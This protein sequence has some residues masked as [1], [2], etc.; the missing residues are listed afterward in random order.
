MRG[1]KWLTGL[2]QSGGAEHTVRPSMGSVQ[3][4]GFRSVQS[5]QTLLDTVERQK[6]VRMLRE[7]CPLSQSACDAFWLKP[8]QQ[9]AGRVQAVPAAWGGPFS[10]SGGFID[11]SLSVATRSVRLVRGMML[12]PGATP[13]AQAEQ[14]PAWVCAV[15]WAGLFH[16]L[17]WLSQM[18]GSLV[19]GKP[20]YPGME[21]P[22]ADWR[23][24]PHQRGPGAM[25]GMYIASRLIPDAA[26]VWLQRWPALSGAL[27]LYLSGQ[28]AQS[29][30]LNRIISDALDS[31]A[32][33]AG[34]GP[35]QS[36][37][38]PGAP[39]GNEQV[40]DKTG[41][42]SSPDLIDDDMHQSS[43]HKNITPVPEPINLASA[44]YDA[45][46][47]DD[48][49]AG[50]EA[51]P[52]T[53]LSA[54]ENRDMRSSEPADESD[55]NASIST[56]ELLSVLD[57]MSGSPASGV[58]VRVDTI[59]SEK[60]VPDVTESGTPGEMFLVWLKSSILDGSVSVNER[61][62]FAHILAQFVFIVS[63]ECFFKYLSLNTNASLD[64]A[65]L[66]KS[67]EM[68]DIHYSRN[69]KGLWHYH[70]YDTP[71]KSG[72]YTKMSGYM[73]SADIIY[74]KGTCPPDSVWLAQRT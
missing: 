41:D 4:G 33:T 29:G 62:S 1:L 48:C 19:S 17:D 67:F 26:A 71:D 46:Q 21:I 3:T 30:I 20:W 31:V 34:A 9:L 54:F 27:F 2:A 25:N 43:R 63:P 7:N 8:L 64:K 38:S 12:P 72:R 47:T 69:G 42:K 65:E 40:D 53:L 5:G 36:A 61:E 35:V 6:L 15:F 13:E 58:E 52:V 74:R 60:S 24:R 22:G 55:P 44:G 14:G 28:K 66:Q 50:N 37:V 68:L 11:L 16:H 59:T 73:L 18:E 10:T 49:V 51:L 70:K 39:A 57:L 32:F 45:N 56:A 23:V